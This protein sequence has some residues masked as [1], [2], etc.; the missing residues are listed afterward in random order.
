[1]FTGAIYDVGVFCCNMYMLFVL[2][3]CYDTYIVFLVLC[4]CVLLQYAYVVLC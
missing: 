1:M 3:C 2:N 4:W